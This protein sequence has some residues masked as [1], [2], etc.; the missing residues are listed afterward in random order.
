MQYH[1]GRVWTICVLQSAVR[2]YTGVRISRFS[3][4]NSKVEVKMFLCL[5]K[6]H[7]MKTYCGVEA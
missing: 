6:H 4:D 2:L 5:A 3:E 1:K 7:A